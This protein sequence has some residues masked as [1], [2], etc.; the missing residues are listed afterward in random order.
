M[1]TLIGSAEESRLHSVAQGALRVVIGARRNRHATAIPY[2]GPGLYLTNARMLV[3]ADESRLRLL[4]FNNTEIVATLVGYDLPSGVGV[5]HAAARDLPEV[6]STDTVPAN[7]DAVWA[8]CYPS[9]DEGE[10][11]RFLPVSLHRGH[12]T[13][14]NQT[15]TSMVSFEDLIRTD[16]AIE[17]GCAGGALV[18]RRG[19]LAGMILGSQSDGVTFSLPLAGIDPIIAALRKGERP[20][21]PYFGL[22]LAAQD[23]RRRARFALGDDAAGPLLAYLI[24]GSPAEKAGA[25]PGDLL[26]SVGGQQVMGVLDAGRLLLRAQPGGAAVELGLR[27]GAGGD[28]RVGV[29]P[30]A[31][32][33]RVMLEPIQEMEETLEL[34]IREVKD[35][36]PGPQGLVVGDVVRGGRGEKARWR[37]GDQIVGIDD[38]SMK[39]VR[40]VNEYFRTRYKDLFTDKPIDRRLGSSY[41]AVIEVRT[42]DGTKAYRRYVNLFP[43]F[44][45]PP[46]F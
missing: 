32:P 42:A 5:L 35:G 9:E 11:V 31:R 3:G 17:D 26:V 30:V 2:G 24:P 12:V 4:T 45:A 15:G 8:V 13:A 39:T 34:S 22:G 44:L 20:A 43:D 37:N 19:R 28:L 1:T 27:R 6:E 41:R 40:A 33:D 14:L 10:I 16:H 38:K 46:V 29:P 23:D 21:R 36:G 7:G 18:D 25:K